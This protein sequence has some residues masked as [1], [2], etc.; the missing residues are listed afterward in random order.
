[1][2]A[3]GDYEVAVQIE[4][5]PPGAAVLQADTAAVTTTVSGRSVSGPAHL[6]R[7]LHAV[8]VRAAGG[9]IEVSAVSL[10]PRASRAAGW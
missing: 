7:G 3:D 4:D 6:A 9:Q 2:P 8:R 10:A 5:G 1:M